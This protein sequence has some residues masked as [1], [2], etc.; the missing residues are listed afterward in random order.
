M[1]K[2]CFSACLTTAVLFAAFP[3]PAATPVKLEREVK[4]QL[5][6]EVTNL[7][8]Y[9]DGV[10]ADAGDVVFARFDSK[11]AKPLVIPGMTAVLEVAPSPG[12]F[13][14]L[15][16]KDTK[17]VLSREAGG[18]E[19]AEVELPE[20]IQ[21]VVPLESKAED[22]PSLLPSNG[23]DSA[24]VRKGFVYRRT[25]GEWKRVKLPETPRFYEEFKPGP[26]WSHAFLLGSVLFAGWDAGEWGGML[27]SIDLDEKQP[28]WKHLSGKPS[29][30]RSGIPGNKP[31]R[32]IVCPDGKSLW[33]GCGLAHLGGHSSSLSCRNPDGTWSHPM[34]SDLA[35]PQ[36]VM[37]LPKESSLAA[38]A[39]NSSGKLHLLAYGSGVYQIGDSLL[40]VLDQDV[41][42]VVGETRG[43]RIGCYPLSLGIA[44]QGD[45]FISTNSFGIFAFHKE[46]DSWEARQILT[47]DR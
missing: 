3:V 42:S 41:S 46:G 7:V 35:R 38:L 13:W 5:E 37:R 6:R 16:W 24:M 47:E 26:M 19:P 31:V 36:G 40:P 27:V 12:G 10:L 43:M 21:K 4:L 18:G 2:L 33:V 34:D 1:M 11:I 23:D 15:G 32:A 44:R 9:R 22:I 45:L 8:P 17:L 28:E 25:G 39:R 30:D 20:E 29:G 14:F